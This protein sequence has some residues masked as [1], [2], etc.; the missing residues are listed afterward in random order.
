MK[1]GN[2]FEITIPA[3]KGDKTLVLFENLGFEILNEVYEDHV[4]LTDGT[5]LFKL[6]S[7]NEFGKGVEYLSEDFEN[8]VRYIESL[9]I[10]FDSKTNGDELVAIHFTDPNNV[11]I[12]ITNA[13]STSFPILEQ[14]PTSKLGRFSELSILTKD[15][16]GTI[17]FWKKLGFKI[18]FGNPDKDSNICLTDNNLIIGIYKDGTCPHKFNTPAITYFDR[19]RPERIEALKKEGIIFVEEMKDAS[20]KVTDGI[21]E[22][23]M[24]Q[25]IFV[26]ST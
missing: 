16:N 19:D 14:K 11:S 25:H 21:I 1:L 13:T 15:F 17:E 20:G 6:D 18:S 3:K 10:S 2:A 7:N 5:T 23:V 24:G 22:T 9:N 8:V 12:H 4:V 26:F